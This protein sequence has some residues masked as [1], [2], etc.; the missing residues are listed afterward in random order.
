[1][2][3]AGLSII[4]LAWCCAASAGT[5]ADTPPATLSRMAD[6]AT[7]LLNNDLGAAA[8]SAQ[9]L[10]DKLQAHPDPALRIRAMKILVQ[11]RFRLG[12][13]KKTVA[14]AGKGMA[15][16]KDDADYAYYVR[17]MLYKGNGQ[18]YLGNLEKAAALYNRAVTFSAA[19]HLKK[20]HPLALENRGAFRSYQGN[21]TK[22]LEDI[23]TAITEYQETNQNERAYNAYTTLSNLYSHMGNYAQAI[24]FLDLA[25]TYF[26]RQG[27]QSAMAVI[28][29]NKAVALRHQGKNAAAAKSYL[30]SR[31]LSESIDDIPGIA[32]AELGA[33]SVLFAEGSVNK[34][35]PHLKNALKR[36][37]ALGDTDEATQVKLVLAETHL[38][39]HHYNQAISLLK[40]C[41]KLYKAK[42][43]KAKIAEIYQH[44]AAAYAKSG[45][46]RQAYETYRDFKTVDDDLHASA[47]EKQLNALRVKFHS[48]Q[49]DRENALLRKENRIKELEL[50]KRQ[51]QL[52]F[53]YTAIGLVVL[54]L[55]LLAYLMYRKIR[56]A[57]H[58]ELL[59]N[60]DTLTGVPNRR[61]ILHRLETAFSLSAGTGRE[62]ALIMF[63]V[64][65]FKSLNDRFG[66][67]VGDRALQAIAADAQAQLR[68]HDSIG[69]IGGEEFLVLLPGASLDTGLAVSER[70]RRTVEKI[71]L[72][73]LPG[74][75]RVTISLGV[76]SITADDANT[77]M[78]MARAD[79]R[80]YEAK[81]AGRNCVRPERTE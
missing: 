61:N 45:D 79:T 40:N 7:Q 23:Q 34:A 11:A 39:L 17:F 18:E 60:M 63:D 31:K 12:E 22:A 10:L 21:Y 71:R 43:T 69:R 28:E 41:L 27:N 20:I 67:A 78:L 5:T 72:P 36:F 9:T 49:Q 75:A 37:K 13:Y 80:L 32:Y 52:A 54:G 73:E 53:Q 59:A 2:R 70:L 47:K 64:D 19:E 68:D 1:M 3:F 14:L 56:Q 48:K 38:A 4:L 62:L 55:L 58:M 44:L 57:R 74:N 33:G 46:Y 42:K 77:D 66:H 15:L 35:L 26:S 16:A 65:Y 25:E 76:V 29:Y 81:E 50:Q 24:H 51:R 30:Q 8:K 6:R